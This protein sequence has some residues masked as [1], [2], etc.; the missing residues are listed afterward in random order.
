MALNRFELPKKQKSIVLI[1][2]K[3]AKVSLV[4]IRSYL[5]HPVNEYAPKRHV[6][7]KLKVEAVFS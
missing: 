1:N 2:Y 7:A 6:I 5:V 4:Y 3:Y